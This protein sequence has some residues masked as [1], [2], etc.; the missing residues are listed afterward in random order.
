MEI[1]DDLEK[2][3]VE[4]WLTSEESAA[5]TTEQRLKE[6]IAQNKERSFKTVVFRSGNTTLAALTEALIRSNRVKLFLNSAPG[7][8]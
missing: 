5:P 2:K 6:I 7:V 4:V 8:K 1:V 3:V